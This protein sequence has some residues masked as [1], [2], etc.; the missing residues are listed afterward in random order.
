MMNSIL[1]NNL[2][3]LANLYEQYPDSFDGLRMQGEYLV[4]GD[5]ACNISR[6]NLYDLVNNNRSFLANIDSLTAED[7]FRIIRL[8]T[9]SVENKSLGTLDQ[10]EIIKKENP[11]L[12]NVTIIPRNERTGKEEIINIVDSNGKDNMFVNTYRID[13]FDLYEDVKANVGSREVTPEDLIAEINR[14]I[15]KI[16]LES[17]RDF[18][19]KSDLSEDFENK[20]TRVNDPYQSSKTTNVYGNEEMDVA[21]VSNELNPDKH[22]VVT[23]S[24]DEFGDTVIE[25]HKQNIDGED[26][27]VKNGSTTTTDTSATKED[28]VSEDVMADDEVEEEIVNLISNEEFYRLVNSN[29]EL[30]PKQKEDLRTYYAFLGDLMIYEE[31]LL[32]ELMEV[33]NTFRAF[34]LDLN[35][36]LENAEAELTINQ[37]DALKKAEELETK[38]LEAQDKVI[39]N[40][41]NFDKTAEKNYQRTLKLERKYQTTSEGFISTFAIISIIVIVVIIMTII[42]LAIV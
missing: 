35:V 10:M 26:T 23:F 3:L 42:T 6:F 14:R 31:Y 22:E 41:L 29:Q 21:L 28:E 39:N 16:E 36:K 34:I 20:I 40:E 2:D 32:P 18:E 9:I 8:H 37:E 1:N 7:I 4:Y 38:A 13:F 15:H 5:D 25:N 24:N 19:E 11:L 27:I 12:K 17:A 30:S 33:L